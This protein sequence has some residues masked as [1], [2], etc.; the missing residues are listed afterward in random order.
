V[1]CK[2]PNDT[3]NDQ[4]VPP[5]DTEACEPW[6]CGSLPDG[7]Q[8]MCPDGVT[9]S[10]PN[11]ECIAHGSVC[12]WKVVSC[13]ITQECEPEDCGLASTRPNYLCTDDK[14]IA[15]PTGRCLF[16]GGACEWEIATCP[17]G[18]D[19]CPDSQCGPAPMLP[20]WVC[21]DGVTVAGPSGVCKKLTGGACEW[22]IVKCSGLN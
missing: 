18:Y 6:D 7:E 3:S 1:S 15:G 16:K 10:G 22:D 14:T 9:L 17:A 12:Q 2:L 5:I 21:P 11:G 4:P 19:I 20:N 13:P 8:V